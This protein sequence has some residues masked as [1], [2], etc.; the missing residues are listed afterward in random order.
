[1][2]LEQILP[3]QLW[4]AIARSG[5]PFGELREIRIRKGRGILILGPKGER[6][7]DSDGKEV[8]EEAMALIVGAPLFKEILE[9]LTGYSLY[10]YQEELGQ[11]YF[12]IRGGHRVGVAGHVIYEK[13]STPRMGDISYLN[14]RFAHEI[15]GCAKWLY[16]MLW[17]KN[18][19]PNTLMIAPPGCGK[20]TYLRDLTRWISEGGKRVCVADERSEIAGGF[21]GE[22]QFNLGIRTDIMDGCPK[23]L[24]MQMLLRSMNPEVLVADEIGL[25][26]DVEAIRSACCCGCRVVATAHAGSLSEVKHNPMLRVLF[27]EKRFGRYV[28]LGKNKTDFY[29]E[30][31]WNEEGEILWSC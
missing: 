18:E 16:S 28:L 20:T 21:R 6:M 27:E 30:C 1:M 26:E 23:S 4:R 10:A 3:E 8:S 17:E 2:E 25:L 29:I 5:I 7:L 12:T 24:A 9:R 11:G 15:V 22:A 13:G 14:L 19:I 31:I